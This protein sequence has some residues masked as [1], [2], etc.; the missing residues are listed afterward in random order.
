MRWL[1]ISFYNIVNVTV[2]QLSDNDSMCV[3]WM[4]AWAKS[5][6]SVLFLM[7][8]NFTSLAFTIFDTMTCCRFLFFSFFLIFFFVVFFKMRHRK[9]FIFSLCVKLPF[10][11]TIK[12]FTFVIFQMFARFV[13]FLFLVFQVALFMCCNVA[14]GNSDDIV[15]IFYSVVECF[16]L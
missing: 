10:H 15:I 7:C 13:S 4:F 2:V 11:Y 3:L 12:S 9:Q 6:A 14:I 5:G 16:S 1:H 8:E